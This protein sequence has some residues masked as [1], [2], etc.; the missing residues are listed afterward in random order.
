MLRKIYLVSP[1]YVDKKHQSPAAIANEKLPQLKSTARKKHGR[2][3]RIKNLNTRMISG[4][5]FV[6]KCKK[7]ISAE[8]H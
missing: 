3:K 8:S 6:I 7:Q 2:E 1:E 5:K 4:L